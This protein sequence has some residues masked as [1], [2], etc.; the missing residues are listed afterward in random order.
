MTELQDFIRKHVIRG[1]CQCGLCIGAP[2]NPEQ[3]QPTGHTADMIFFKVAAKDDPDPKEFEK[4]VREECPQIFDGQEHSYMNLGAEL[5]DQ[6][7]A[8]EVM[9]LGNL[10]GLWSLL[11]PRSVLG[12]TID[13]AMVQNMAGMGMITVQVPNAPTT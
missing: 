9:G 7:Y 5:G 11:T 6:G 1:A 12:S 3:H 8:M 4:I 13:D 10:L 2:A